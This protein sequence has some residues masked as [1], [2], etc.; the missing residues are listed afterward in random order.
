[1][2]KLALVFTFAMMIGLWLPTARAQAFGDGG[3]HSNRGATGQWRVMQPDRDYGRRVY[4]GH[5][6]WERAWLRRH[7]IRERRA[8][9]RHQLR[10]RRAFRRHYWREHYWR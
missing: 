8:L 4:R 6:R 9:R 1:M 7:Q 3:W 10:E 5:E 2:K